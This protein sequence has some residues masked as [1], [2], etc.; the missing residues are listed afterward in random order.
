VFQKETEALLFGDVKDL[1]RPCS[2]REALAS[3][4]LLDRCREQLK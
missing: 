1:I 2:G 4:E 3:M